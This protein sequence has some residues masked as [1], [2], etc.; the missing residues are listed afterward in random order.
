MHGVGVGTVCVC[1]VC[2]S[3]VCVGGLPGYL[4]GGREKV[5]GR[6]LSTR[7]RPLPTRTPVSVLCATS[8]VSPLLA[9]APAFLRFL[10]VFLIESF[11]LGPR[12][13]P[14]DS[15]LRRLS[16]VIYLLLYVPHPPPGW[17]RRGWGVT[18]R[19]RFPSR[20]AC[21][22]PYMSVDPGVDS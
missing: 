18:D 19:L 9:P 14:E 16:F 22:P 3:S 12:D 10:S 6:V 13:S 2:V 21:C 7:F 20:C 1:V 17:R 5:L 8:L 15:G 4:V 11:T